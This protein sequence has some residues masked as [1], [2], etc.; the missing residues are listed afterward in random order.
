MGIISAAIV[1]K[2]A[3]FGVKVLIRL[4][5]KAHRGPLHRQ[6]EAYRKE[7]EALD[8]VNKEMESKNE[9]PV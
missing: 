8:K 4:G 1:T 6:A 5:L 7:L 3:D 9:K 2:L